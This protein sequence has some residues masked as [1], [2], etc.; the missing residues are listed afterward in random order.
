MK[1][2]LRFASLLLA[3]LFIASL[4]PAK[5]LADEFSPYESVETLEDGVVLYHNKDGSYTMVV[6]ATTDGGKGAGTDRVRSADK[7]VENEVQVQIEKQFRE[8]SPLATIE[9]AGGSLSFFPIADMKSAEA[10]EAFSKEEDAKAEAGAEAAE[11][12]KKSEEVNAKKNGDDIS[13]NGETEAGAENGSADGKNTLPKDEEPTPEAPSTD[14]DPADH[15]NSPN[16]EEQASETPTSVRVSSF[17]IPKDEEG[18]PLPL[19]ETVVPANTEESEIP[20][21]KDVEALDAENKRIAVPVSAWK[22]YEGAYGDAQAEW[23]F[24]PVFDESQIL[25]APALSEA[26]EKDVFSALPHVVIRRI[27]EDAD[28]DSASDVTEEDRQ[29]GQNL[30]ETE[31]ASVPSANGDSTAASK[32]EENAQ[33]EDEDATLSPD[34]QTTYTSSRRTVSEQEETHEPTVIQ[35]IRDRSDAIVY[36]DVFCEGTGIR[37]RATENGI[38]EDILIGGYTPQAEYRYQF[39]MDGFTPVLQGQMVALYRD[40]EQ[41]GTI[42]APYMTDAKGAYCDR[43][44]VSLYGK[45]DGVFELV[46]TP[47][48]GWLG[49]AERAYPV[50]LDPTIEVTVIGTSTEH[51]EDNHVSKSQPNKQFPYDATEIRAGGDY[52]AY[53]RPK[54]LEDLAKNNV[55]ILIKKATLHLYCKSGSGTLN[56]H[57]VQGEWSSQTI[58]YNNKPSYAD[59]AF[60]S[61]A[62]QKGKVDIDITKPFSSWFHSIDQA[63]SFGVA[64]EGQKEITF[65]SADT[66]INRMVYSATYYVIEEANTLKASPTVNA[67]QKT[68]YV[69]LT[70]KAIPNASGYY[71]GI[72]NGKID[73]KTDTYIYEYFYA[74]NVTSWSTKGRNIWPT[75]AEIAAGR[76][77]LHVD[78]TGGAELPINPAPTYEK[79]GS[80]NESLAYYFD[81][82]PANQY[83]QAANL[84]HTR[85]CI[86]PQALVPSQPASVMVSP[87]TWTN[88]STVKVSWSGIVEYLVDGTLLK[89]LEPGGQIQYRINNSGAW[90][91]TGSRAVS[92]SFEMPVSA[93]SSGEHVVSI[94]AK[95]K[96][97]NEG[98]ARDANFR[99]DRQGPNLKTLS[100]EPEYT[101]DTAIRVTWSD[102][103]DQGCGTI[104]K[105]EYRIDNGAW[106]GVKNAKPSGSITVPVTSLSAGAHTV[107]M[108]GT[109]T[110]GNIGATVSAGFT[111]DTTAPSMSELAVIPSEWT[112]ETEAT[113][114]WSGLSDTQSGVKS[115]HYTV[116]GKNRKPLDHTQ[117]EGSVTISLEGLS[118]GEHTVVL[119]YADAVGNTGSKMATVY[120][121]TT[122]PAVEGVTV[123]PDGWSSEDKIELAWQ[124]LSDVHAG[125]ATLEYTVDDADAVP[126]DASLPDG[127]VEIET[128]ALADGAHTVRLVYRDHAQ[129]EAET[130]LLFYRDITAPMA[131]LIQPANGDLVNGIVNVTGTAMDQTALQSWELRAVGTSGA[132]VVVASGTENKENTLLGVLD[133]GV[134]A[135]GEEIALTL[136][137]TDRAGNTQVTEGTVIKVDKSMTDIAASLSLIAP[138]NGEIITDAVYRGEYSGET[139]SGRV[140]VDG[141]AYLQA[142]EFAFEFTALQ[143]EEES[144]HTFSILAEDE[145]GVLSYSEGF[146]ALVIG[147]DSPNASET[148]I[149]EPLDSLKPILAL[150]L[151]ATA[152]EAGSIAYFYSTDDG[153]TWNGIEP[154]KDVRVLGE[155]KRVWLKAEPQDGAVL[156]GWDLSAII[157]K[158]PAA[159]IVRL[160]G[161]VTPFSLTQSNP[162]QTGPK[163]AIETNLSVPISSRWL[164][165]DG[166]SV[167]DTD[168]AYETLRTE[169]RGK[170]S[171]AA[172]ALG[173]DGTLY[174]SGT[175]TREQLL[176]ENVQSEERIVLRD[177]LQL[178][179]KG[180]IYAVR[181]LAKTQS[182]GCRFYVSADG[183]TWIEAETE[184][185]TMLPQGAKTLFLKA[186]QTE[187]EQLL[188]WS[189][190]GIGTTDKVYTVRLI[191]QPKNPIVKDYGK[192]DEK[193]YELSWTKPDAADADMKYVVYKNGAEYAVVSTT[194]FVDAEYDKDAVYSVSA[195]KI[196]PAGAAAY[197]TYPVRESEAVAAQKQVMEPPQK[198]VVPSTP[199]RVEMEDA[200]ELEYH[201]ITERE[202]ASY[203]FTPDMLEP[204]EGPKLDQKLLG[205]NKYCSLGF[206]PVNFNTGNFFL[207]TTDYAQADIGRTVSILRTYNAQS[208]VAD[209]PFGEKW[210]FPYGQFLELYTSGSIGYRN[211]AGALTVFTPDGAGGFTGNDEDY[212]V[213]TEDRIRGE[214]TV[215]EKDGTRTVFEKKSGWLVRIEDRNG[216]ALRLHRAKTGYL[217]AIELASGAKLQ[218]TTDEKGHITEI[219]LPDKTAL[220]YTYDG[221]RL[222]SFTDQAGAVT[223]Y[224][225]DAKGR[226]TAWHDALGV[227]QVRNTYDENDRVVFQTDGLNGEYRLEYFADHTVVTDALGKSSEI[228]FDSLHRTI[229][230]VNAQGAS[231]EYFYDENNNLVGTTDADGKLTSSEY[232]ARGNHLKN[233]LPD[234]STGAKTYD[235]NDNLTSYTDG[236]GSTT[237]YTYD[238]RGNVLTT[239][240]ALG[241]VTRCTYNEK[242]QVI[243]VTDALGGVTT[244]AYRGANVIRA[245]DVNGHVTTYDYDSA[246]R[247]VKMTDAL[248]KTTSYTYDA[249]GRLIGVRYANGAVTRYAYDAVGSMIETTDA[250]G[251]ATAYEYDALRRMTATVYADGARESA[252]YDLGGNVVSETDALGNTATYTY[253][254]VGNLLTVTDAENN[255]TEYAYDRQNRVTQETLP[256]GA[257][258]TYA[259][260]PNSGLVTETTD[261]RGIATALTYDK[262][263]N[264]LSR[265]QQSGAATAAEYDALNRVI[266]Q[267]DANGGVT[268]YRYDALGRVIEQTNALGGTTR[269]GYDAVGNLT[270]TTDALGNTT[271]AKYD[272]LNRLV[273]VTDPLGAT[274]TYAYDAVGNLTAV[275]DPLGNREKYRYNLRGDL[276]AMIDADGNTTTVSYDRR[277]R[278]LSVIE[279]NGNETLYTFDALGNPIEI[280]D[281]D[282]EE[283]HGAGNER[284]QPASATHPRGE[285]IAYICDELGNVV[286]VTDAQEQSEGSGTVPA[287]IKLVGKGGSSAVRLAGNGQSNASAVATGSASRARISRNEAILEANAREWNIFAAQVRYV[288]AQERGVASPRQNSKIMFSCKTGGTSEKENV[289][290]GGTGVT[291]G[292]YQG[293]TSGKIGGSSSSNYTS[294]GHGGRWPS[295][296]SNH[297]KGE[298]NR[299]YGSGKEYSDNGLYEIN[300]RNLYKMKHGKPPIGIDGKRVILHHLEGIGNNMY[301]YEE[302]LSSVHW[303][304]SYSD[305]HYFLYKK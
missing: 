150:R 242:G 266:R 49:A 76:Y 285:V 35:G 277:N 61:I 39:Q 147:S 11:E 95:D 142:E 252:V 238:E 270:E 247:V 212:L 265:T 8:G 229:R 301:Y 85:P 184:A 279:P 151:H 17:A 158:A 140:Y 164:Y 102:L 45:G 38:K 63:G 246:G 71:V 291:A 213:L 93:V 136:A 18:N 293:S 146:A 217:N 126:L 165:A 137:V 60:S 278:L 249:T 195:R 258:R 84:K 290:D 299:Y 86:F 179:N 62:V 232:D 19:A 206:E 235:G 216:N 65:A 114:G 292:G 53:I 209:G 171:L 168:F 185:Y 26:M 124:G 120:R 141:K 176:R 182:E 111:K 143:F 28:E 283:A 113:I 57:Q 220:R 100:A 9:Y 152:S 34:Q 205:K 105:L 15:L 125:A 228:R 284:I 90:K 194:A 199:S 139:A 289:A 263:G 132:E 129:N 42:L 115:L 3:M 32:E 30:P 208:T 170:V 156:Y 43:I 231:V 251:N 52:I 211:A 99:I 138:Q 233:T 296:R 89:E 122:P 68:G 295:V 188:A 172:L 46:Y 218:I 281:E 5:A 79:A 75:E 264:V 64:L 294:P 54:Y 303:G 81:I 134:F 286:P 40:S 237:S 108:R 78:E 190:E 161:T 297:W 175:P 204:K 130:V 153:A 25:F 50:V 214:Y 27:E 29:S 157:E 66:P 261:A 58:T 178:S 104:G 245:T 267:T 154:E 177:A 159:A 7:P 94:R 41:V 255:R 24:F 221:S 223:R 148:Y 112:N 74:G 162:L 304:P 14:A 298:Y 192:F 37:L 280:T 106:T 234:G 72:H 59:E 254:A 160:N 88:A 257:V 300:K 4:V 33:R 116:D 253:D 236:N 101:K 305:L 262:A 23:V 250:L 155:V 20:F 131:R 133:T 145:D 67:D 201:A 287:P 69:D 240:D 222:T 31:G 77:N 226:M 288:R 149:S 268:S 92:G 187:A 239:T 196:Y 241:N 135:D 56:V 197:T 243:S 302:M 117:A 169:E 97:G 224:E 44:D 230:E 73:K 96:D 186:E 22:V 91:D 269:Y 121:D 215:L 275:T 260:D 276:I 16:E 191:E 6:G 225:Y 166:I 82:R 80:G 272:A 244:Y 210:A 174:A 227:C 271:K 118:D 51:M 127:S 1:Q 163:Q 173:E 202:D 198:P 55:A 183:E 109:D 128:D 2:S 103:T 98:T 181:L 83:G 282:D 144:S 200:P 107:S 21:P 119:E 273:S 207:E 193:R 13:N 110:L 10:S 256:T 123:T 180:T 47:D 248:G 274:T 36:E 87:S 203:L 167:N 48:D 189:L 12:D 259:Y 219:R 70:W